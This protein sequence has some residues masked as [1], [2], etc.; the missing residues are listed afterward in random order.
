MERRLAKQLGISYDAYVALRRDE[1]WLTADEAVEMGFADALIDNFYYEV[2]PPAD[3]PFTLFF[4][5]LLKGITNGQ[6][7]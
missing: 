4:G 1:R 5:Q 2:E 7:K 6:T 3:N